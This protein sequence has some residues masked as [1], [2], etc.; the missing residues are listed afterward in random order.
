MVELDNVDP[1]L[2]AL[3]TA[4]PLPAQR[5]AAW[6]PGHDE[7]SPVATELHPDIHRCAVAPRVCR[8]RRPEHSEDD[9]RY[10]QEPES[11]SHPEILTGLGNARSA[12]AT[13]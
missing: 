3:R 13:R 7:R 6:A 1:A 4:R 12:Y 5:F 11:G 9:D 2:A 8:D 10:P